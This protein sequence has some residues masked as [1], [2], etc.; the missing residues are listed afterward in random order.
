MS[1][2][3]IFVF[4]ILLILA[5]LLIYSSFFLSWEIKIE[6]LKHQTASLTQ[7]NESKDSEITIFAVGDIMLNRGVEWYTERNNDWRWPFLK[8]AEDLRKADILFGNLEGPISDKGERVGSIYSFRADPKVL[9]GLT[10]AGFDILSLA[11]NHMLDYQRVALEDAMMRLQDNEIDYVGAGFNK[12]EAFSVKVREI[13][14]TKIGFLAYTNLGPEVWRAGDDYSGI[15]WLNWDDIEKIREDIK[16]AKKE[17]DVLIVSLHSGEEY[18]KSP[19]HFQISFNKACIEAGADLVVGHHSHVIQKIE[20][21]NNGWIAYSLGNFVFDQGFSE[22]TMR[23]LLLKILIKDKKIKEI[24]P[25]N[26]KLN[27]S[28]QPEIIYP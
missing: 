3:S 10:Y 8:I 21:Y 7:I 22:E 6:S 24:T 19:T 5:G 14:N 12:R 15:A 1:R 18:S 23:G 17:V 9:E 13:R 27:N 2:F 26:I 25:I 20:R 16:K 4:I 11:N 28:F